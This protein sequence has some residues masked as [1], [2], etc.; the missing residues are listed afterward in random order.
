MTTAY[1]QS[2]DTDSDTWNGNTFVQRWAAS[3]L[4]LPSDAIARMR[5]RWEAGST[6]ALT[7]SEAYVGHKA[8]SGDVYDFAATP[9]QFLFSGG[10][11]GVANAGSTITSDWV[12]FVYDKTTDLLISWYAG[13]GTSS[14]MT[15]YKDGISASIIAYFKAGN[16]AS[17][18]DKSAS[19]S[20]AASRLRSITLL[21]VETATGGFFLFMR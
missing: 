21:E 14:D 2:V 15:R 17:T 3:D 20:S 10:A 1:S 4:T 8:G 5:A 7:I 19:Y 9:A 11:S 16:E 18:V 12:N 6:E 13:G